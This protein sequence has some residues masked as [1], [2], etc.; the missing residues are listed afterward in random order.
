MPRRRRRHADDRQD[1]QQPA[2]AAPALFESLEPR[3]MLTVMLDHKGKTLTITGSPH[4]DHILIQ[5][6]PDIPEK[7]FIRVNGVVNTM[8]FEKFKRINMSTGRGNDTIVLSDRYGQLPTSRV[9]KVSGDSDNDTITG[10][11][12]PDSL[13]GGGGDDVLV[14]NGGNDTLDGGAGDDTV[15]GG[16][17]TD[18]LLGGDGDDLINANTGADTV[19]GGAGADVIYGGTGDDSIHGGDGDDTIYGNAD[20]DQLFGDAGVDEIHDGPGRDIITP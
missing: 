18:S 10:G 8:S 14:G 2:P 20:A 11:F 13:F 16:N 17:G 15:T 19:E 5:R 7:V 4:A 12:G 1:S 9:I 6:N 3:Q